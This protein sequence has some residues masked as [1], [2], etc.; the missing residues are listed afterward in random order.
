MRKLSLRI[1]QPGIKN[2]LLFGGHILEDD[3]HA[4]F[5]VDVKDTRHTFEFFGAVHKAD[6]DSRSLR[7]RIGRT[8]VASGRT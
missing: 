2:A 7:E 5:R 4:E 3:A 8:D 1:G 6:A